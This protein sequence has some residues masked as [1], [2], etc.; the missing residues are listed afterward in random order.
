MR[1]AAV[2]FRP[3]FGNKEKNIKRIIQIIDGID[4]ELIVLPEL[5]TTGYYFLSRDESAKFAEPAAGDTISLFRKIASDSGKTI[6]IGFAEKDGDKIYNSS[7]VI[8]PYEDA[9][10]KTY[11]KTHL[12]YRERFSFDEGDSGFFIVEDKKNDIKIG[13]MICYDWRFPEAARSLALKGADLIVCPSN[14]VTDV[15]HVSMPSRALE[16]K[17]YLAVANRTGTELRNGEEL[18]F[19]GKSA[20]YSYNGKT[21]ALAS[22]KGEEIIYADIEPQKTRNKSFNPYNDIFTDR[23]PGIYEK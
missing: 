20:I 12:F 11:R 1:I 2:Q 23:R 9:E 4:A 3:E 17:V 5:C 6:V 14:L 22:E 18:Y 15:W 7:A 10:I 19:N 13:Q 16:N 21:M 8:F